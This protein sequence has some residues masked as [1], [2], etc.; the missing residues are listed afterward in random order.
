MLETRRARAITAVAHPVATI[1]AGVLAGA[2]LA[3]WLTESSLDGSAE[4]WIG[5]H[6]AITSAYTRTL[7][8]IGI[9]A[10]VAA[11]WT[12][13]TSWRNV[14]IRWLL[15]LATWCLLFGLAVTIAVHFPIN[16]QVLSWQPAD[17]PADWEDVRLRWFIAHG[18][19]AVF[20]LAAFVLFVLA[21]LRR[22]GHQPSTASMDETSTR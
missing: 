12:L 17:P 6:Q 20:A 11:G 13:A 22:D 14:P 9:L 5:Y 21:T 8:T 1:L 2:M 18:I 4:L 7:P 19:R 10:L 16:A 15:F 3:A